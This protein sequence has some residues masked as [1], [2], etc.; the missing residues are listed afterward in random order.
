MGAGDWAW[1]VP[2]KRR[3]KQKVEQSVRSIFNG[4][5]VGEERIVDESARLAD[6]R[7]LSL[8]VVPN[9]KVVHRGE[10]FRN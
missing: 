8:I 5:R 10:R 4:S 2:E 9:L 6:S 1:I 7:I 3:S